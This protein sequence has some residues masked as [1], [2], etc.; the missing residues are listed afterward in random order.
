M[1]DMTSLRQSFIH[2]WLNERQREK[3]LDEK[4]QLPLRNKLQNGIA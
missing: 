2:P 1:R 4:I 3:D